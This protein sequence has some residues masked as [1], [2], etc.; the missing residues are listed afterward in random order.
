MRSSI[1]DEKINL[2]KSL[3]G[4]YKQADKEMVVKTI[5]AYKEK[6]NCSYRYAY[7]MNVEGNPSFSSYN[8]WRRK[9]DKVN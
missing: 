8:S 5:N 2:V 6:H 9:F 1:F 4:K 3:N 7:E